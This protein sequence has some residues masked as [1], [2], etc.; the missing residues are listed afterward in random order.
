MFSQGNTEIL[1]CL[2]FLSYGSLHEEL[3]VYIHISSKATKVMPRQD[4]KILNLFLFMNSGLED[5]GIEKDNHHLHLFLHFDAL[6]PWSL[7]D[8][9]VTD[10]LTVS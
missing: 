4:F 10:P 3:G 7:A 9:G 2:F 6:A 5:I 1:V 8:S